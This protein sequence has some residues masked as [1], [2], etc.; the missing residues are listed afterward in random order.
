MILLFNLQPPPPSLILFSKLRFR[1]NE[2]HW[3][4]LEKNYILFCPSFYYKPSLPLSSR[5]NAKF[6]YVS[7]KTFWPPLKL[8][9]PPVCPYS[10]AFCP[11]QSIGMLVANGESTFSS[12]KFHRFNES[13][14]PSDRNSS[15]LTSKSIR[16][17]ECIILFLTYS[18]IYASHSAT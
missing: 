11:T 12:E 4:E 9:P 7:N 3:A 5:S 8:S 16:P 6:L 18:L 14:P 17:A 10:R 13:S 2:I 15:P 1:P